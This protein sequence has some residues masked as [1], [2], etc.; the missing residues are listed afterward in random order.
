MRLTL[1]IGV[2]WVASALLVLASINNWIELGDFEVAAYLGQLIL[3]VAYVLRL[4]S[5][6][7]SKKRG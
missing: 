5:E 3:V 2:A 4:H 7:L 1:V 6:K